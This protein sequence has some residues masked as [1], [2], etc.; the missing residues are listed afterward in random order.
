MKS[1][2]KKFLSTSIGVGFKKYL[3][4]GVVFLLIGCLAAGYTTSNVSNDTNSLLILIINLIAFLF[5]A[6]GAHCCG[7]YYGA[8]KLYLIEKK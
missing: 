6:I 5:D 2:Q 4:I 1:D 7:I 3:I 8:Y